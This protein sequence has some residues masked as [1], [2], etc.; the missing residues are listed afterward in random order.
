MKILSITIIDIVLILKHYSDHD[1]CCVNGTCP[2]SSLSSALHN[3]SDNTVINIT[4]ESVTLH[5]IV[6]MGSGNLSNI[7]ITGNG[8]TIMCNNTGGVYCDS[9]SNI[10]IMGITWYQCGGND[11]TALTFINLSSQILI[12]DCTFQNCP[13]YIRNAKGNVLIKE[14]NFIADVFHPSCS[15]SGLHISYDAY[16]VIAINNS[17]FDG[18]SCAL[19]C[20]CSGVWIEPSNNVTEFNQFLFKKHKLFQ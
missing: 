19:E 1:T 13:V 17:K 14:S 4:S 12:Q 15:Y 11:S 20:N 18:N 10:T 5:D 7:T 6:G 3:V 2:C 9:C 8:A 16:T